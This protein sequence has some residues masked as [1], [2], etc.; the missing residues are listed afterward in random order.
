MTGTETDAATARKCGRECPCI[1]DD[2]NDCDLCTTSRPAEK[3]I[4]LCERFGNIDCCPSKE[5]CPFRQYCAEH[6]RRIDELLI[7][8]NKALGIPVPAELP[9]PWRINRPK[10]YC[11]MSTFN[12]REIATI[13]IIL[14]AF[15]GIFVGIIIGASL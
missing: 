3:S 14:G 15:S 2:G 9:C 8:R 7:E 5:Q 13:C 10:R 12:K 11:G 6:Y 1:P 4:S